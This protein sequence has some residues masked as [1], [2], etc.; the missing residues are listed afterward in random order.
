MLVKKLVSQYNTKGTSATTP[1]PEHPHIACKRRGKAAWKASQ[2][3]FLLRY[4]PDY[5]RA[6]RPALWAW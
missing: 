1:A 4:L 2:A 6:R 3:A 5:Q